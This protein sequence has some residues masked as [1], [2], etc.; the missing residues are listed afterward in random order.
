MKAR[1]SPERRAKSSTTPGFNGAAPMKARKWELRKEPNPL[2]G[3][4]MG[5]RR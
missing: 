1:K 5:P 2:K 3:A 4:S